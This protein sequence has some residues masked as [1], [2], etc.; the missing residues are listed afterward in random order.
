MP[1]VVRLRGLCT[2]IHIN[3]TT[4]VT[5]RYSAF[6]HPIAV[7]PHVRRGCLTENIQ[8]SH[9]THATETN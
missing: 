4:L 9:L 5:G 6:A 8:R 2:L 3:F 1:R 7:V